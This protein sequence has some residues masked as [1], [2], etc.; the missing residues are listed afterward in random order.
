[1]KNELEEWE[2]YTMHELQLHRAINAVRLEVEKERLLAK[3]DSIK[4]GA[5]GSVL[6]YVVRNF[7]TLSRTVG[8][9]TTTIGIIRKIYSLAKGKK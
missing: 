8:I 1:M 9:A 3:F 4:A 5:T 7:G 2:G 6:N